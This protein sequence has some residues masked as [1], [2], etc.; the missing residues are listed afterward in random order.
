[1]EA[2]K[3]G[4]LYPRVDQSECIH[5]D[6]CDKVCPIGQTKPTEETAVVA[7][8]A[9]NTDE[10]VRLNSSSGG[11]FT[12]L[13]EELLDRGGVVFGAAFAPDLS[14][15]HIAVE[16]KEDLWKLRGSKYLQSVIGDCYNEVKTYLKE[17]R[18]VLFSGTPCQ[19]AGLDAFLGKKYDTLYTQDF[20]CHGVP[21]PLVWQS[22]LGYR[23]NRSGELPQEVSF[24][25]KEDGWRRYSVRLGYPDRSVM[26]IPLTNDPM[27]RLFLKN[28]CLRPSCYACSFKGLERVSDITLGDFWGVERLLEEKD[29]DKGV[30]LVLLQSEKGKRLFEAVQAKLDR[31]AVDAKEALRYNSAATSSVAEPP[32]RAA[33]FRDL[34]DTGFEKTAKRYLKDPLPKRIR[35]LLSKIKRIILRR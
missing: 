8:A 2:D 7:Y 27:M 18:L 17:G 28:L 9:V 3:E 5:C 14:V 6:L 31:R 22:Y 12:L 30:S 26:R 35:A 1:M 25:D 23:R 33:F 32:D 34:T 10:S 29:D 16:R 11:V 4:F 19:V 20:V 21:S 13:A 24:R 15:K